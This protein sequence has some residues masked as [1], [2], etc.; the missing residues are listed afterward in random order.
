MFSNS[1]DAQIWQERNCYKCWKYSGNGTEREKMR[2]KAAFDID[3]GYVT[4]ELT[5]RVDRI[6]EMTDCPHRQ[7]K[8][9][10]YKK[11]SGA[12]PLFEGETSANA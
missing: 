12:M 6:T 10:I 9:P 7:G 3:L 4:G 8:R 2:C 5:K 1:I 11:H